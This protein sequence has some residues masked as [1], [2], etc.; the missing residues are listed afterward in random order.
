M[1]KF[2]QTYK[3]IILHWTNCN[4]YCIC[5]NRNQNVTSTTS[6]YHIS[7]EQNRRR[8]YSK[9]IRSF[10]NLFSRFSW[11]YY[12]VF[13]CSLYPWRHFILSSKGSR[14]S[15]QRYLPYF[16]NCQQL[17]MIPVQSRRYMVLRDCLYVLRMYM[18]EGARKSI[19]SDRRQSPR[20]A[21]SDK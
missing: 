13:L 15:F 17:T 5:Y 1:F 3:I 11:H 18:Y 7:F 21:R 10:A 19:T 2:E 12:F 16:A 4:K 8:N 20:F 9:S 6:K 14:D